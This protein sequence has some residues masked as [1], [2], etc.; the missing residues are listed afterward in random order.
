MTNAT[1]EAPT[2][3]AA[4]EL[5]SLRRQSRELEAQLEQ[6]GTQRGRL[7]GDL[8]QAGAP[9]A[10]SEK[11]RRIIAGKGT[12]KAA[13]AALELVR[14]DEREAALTNARALIDEAI[15]PLERQESLDALEPLFKAAQALIL[16]RAALQDQQE[17]VM[18]EAAAALFAFDQAATVRGQASWWTLTHK[19]GLKLSFNPEE[20]D[21]L[22]M[23]Q[24]DFI[25][26]GTGPL[27][28]PTKV[29]DAL[30]QFPTRI[31]QWRERAAE[32]GVKLTK[33]AVWADRSKGYVSLPKPRIGGTAWVR[34]RTALADAIGTGR[35]GDILEVS[36]DEAAALVDG[37]FAE[38]VTKKDAEDQVR[39]F[40]TGYRGS[41]K[42]ADQD[43][44][45]H[46]A[47]LADPVG[48]APVKKHLAGVAPN[49]DRGNRDEEDWTPSA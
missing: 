17:A 36:G 41:G 10:L 3:S 29:R 35:P 21:L 25:P 44:P 24:S 47:S 30:Y 7:Q 9:V 33:P 15:R 16:K 20:L 37:G 4:G 40:K 48:D 28:S 14:L 22:R 39:R 49:S 12:E 43:I 23:W 2:T 34:L 26:E 11:V 8:H 46:A 31:E 32:L 27:S 45:S 19:Q 38:P 5:E 42:G 6:L 1:T 18:K 13:A